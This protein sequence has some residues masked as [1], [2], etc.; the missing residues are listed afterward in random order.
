M[1]SAPRFLSVDEVKE[2]HD[3]EI[4]YAGGPSGMREL[5]SLESAIGAPQTSFNGKFLMD[6]FEM[7]A[8]YLNSIADT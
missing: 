2:I 4:T 3:N 1:I 6:L 7:A 8:T 5:K